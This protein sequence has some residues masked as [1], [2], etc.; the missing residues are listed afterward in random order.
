MKLFPGKQKAA[1]SSLAALISPAP[2]ISG[3][4][5]VARALTLRL[6]F[7][8]LAGESNSHSI[9]FTVERYGTE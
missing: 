9:C 7:F 1:E 8:S 6:A 4:L 5:C 2:P 3:W